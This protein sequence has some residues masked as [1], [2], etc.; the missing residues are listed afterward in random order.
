MT[1]LENIKPDADLGDAHLIQA[2][3]APHGS[4]SHDDSH[5]DDDTVMDTAACTVALGSCLPAG[6]SCRAFGW[7]DGGWPQFWAKHRFEHFLA[8][9]MEAPNCAV[10]G[11]RS[12]TLQCGSWIRPMFRKKSARGGVGSRRHLCSRPSWPFLGWLFTSRSVTFLIASP[13]RFTVL[14]HGLHNTTSTKA[15]DCDRQTHFLRSPRSSS[16]EA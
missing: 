14:S 6:D 7:R 12:S 8:P 15:M 4:T 9:V 5:A 13:V 2:A 11:A 3:P 10:N 1:F 16:G